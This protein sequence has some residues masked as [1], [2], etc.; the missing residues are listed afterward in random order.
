MP[1]G[2]TEIQPA[3]KVEWP[4]YYPDRP[5]SE[6]FTLLRT[7]YRIRYEI[8]NEKPFPCPAGCGAIGLSHFI[9]ERSWHQRIILG[10]SCSWTVTCSTQPTARDLKEDAKVKVHFPP[11]ASKVPPPPDYS[12]PA[13]VSARCRERGTPGAWEG[14][15]TVD[16]KFKKLYKEFRAIVPKLKCR[17]EDLHRSKYRI[18]DIG[19]Y[20]RPEL[21]LEEIPAEERKPKKRT[22]KAS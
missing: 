3:C 8:I 22:R 2:Q 21:T 17:L 5:G 18:V 11:D 9:R 10:C 13:K 20:G 15:I 16:T 12:T 14:L 4:G 7:F 19:K 1:G 6:H